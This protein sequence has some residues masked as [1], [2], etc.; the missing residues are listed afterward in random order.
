MKDTPPDIW[1]DWLLHHRHGGD[2]KQLQAVMEH[3][4]PVRD[5][6]IAMTELGPG[7]TLLDVGCG[8]GLIGFG[9]LQQVP[10]A[11]VIFSDISPAL[12]DQVHTLAED[13]QVSNHVQLLEASA[14][15]LT[16]LATARV[17]AVTTRSVLIYVEDKAR[18]FQEF[19]RVLKPG[20][21]L[22][23]FEPINS[24]NLTGPQDRLG[25]YDVRAVAD[26]ADQVK[27][28]FERYQPPAQDPML[29]FDERDLLSWV[30][31]A[32]FEEIHLDYQV[33]IEPLSKSGRQTFGSWE[34]FLK[35]SPNP[36]LPTFG[37]IMAEALDDEDLE[38]FTTHFRPLVDGQIGIYTLA[39]AYLKAV[40]TRAS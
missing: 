30:L 14:E 17:D 3:L 22:A 29:N 39:I 34:V 2:L 21:R 19:F 16:A 1:S 11:Q 20:G 10:S 5:T 8:D 26:L 35:S 18:A 9:A 32:D 28:V 15:D 31:Q 12:L 24:F 4:I 40:K 13:M 23:I 36:K 7:E 38:T 6:I 27:Q 25:G 33:T 37:E